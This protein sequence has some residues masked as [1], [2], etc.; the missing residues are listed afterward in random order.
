MNPRT[1]SVV[2]ILEELHPVPY[3]PVL[4]S[5]RPQFKLPLSADGAENFVIMP[6]PRSVPQ[7]CL[8]RSMRYMPLS[9][10]IRDVLYG[11]LALFELKVGSGYARKP[12]AIRW[13][14]L[15]KKSKLAA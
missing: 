7:V 13:I 11:V 1:W 12:S 14:W 9:S 5:Q 10:L 3:P 15:M 6:Q 2:Y 4:P 8:A